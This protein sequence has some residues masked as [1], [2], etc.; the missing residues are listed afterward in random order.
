VDEKIRAGYAHAPV[1]NSQNM[2]QIPRGLRRRRLFSKA[3]GRVVKEAGDKSGGKATKTSTSI[4]ESHAQE[5]KIAVQR[6]FV[7]PS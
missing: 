1:V 2:K 7:N 3:V 4:G 5:E 6:P